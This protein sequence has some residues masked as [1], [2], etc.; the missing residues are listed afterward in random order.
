MAKRKPRQRTPLQ[1]V[2]TGP[3][4]YDWERIDE[5]PD[6]RIIRQENEARC[7]A[8]CILTLLG[9]KAAMTQED[10]AGAG[11]L[12]GE[13]ASIDQI[14]PTLRQLDPAGQWVIRSH[15]ESED[16]SY[17]AKRTP[18]IAIL[19]LSGSGGVRSE[20]HAVLVERMD[21]QGALVIADPLEATHYR[22]RHEAFN[23]RWGGIA[24]FRAK[25]K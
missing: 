23:E 1:V 17:L 25:Q 24:I 7:T 19:L 10:L 11:Y 14:A 13:P 12:H 6:L 3:F 16:F 4:P 21:R 22:M 18:W 9:K 15:A 2:K 8:A 20:G 5:Q